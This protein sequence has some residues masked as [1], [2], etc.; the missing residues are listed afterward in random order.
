VEVVVVVDR[1]QQLMTGLAGINLAGDGLPEIVSLAYAGRSAGLG[2]PDPQ[3]R[4]VLVLV[5]SRLLTPLIGR[6]SLV[7]RLDRLVTDVR[8][9]GNDCRLVA[10]QLYQGG[11]QKDGWVLLALRR[12]L[13]Q[14]RDSLGL[15]AVVLVGRFPEAQ[16]LRRF[17]WAPA[18]ERAIS[19]VATAGRRYLA[20]D[21]ELVAASA[22]IVLADLTGRWERLYRPAVTTQAL[23]LLPN[24]ADS[25][26]ADWLRTGREITGNVVQFDPEITTRDVFYLDEA[27]LQQNLIG[28]VARVTIDQ[29]RTDPEIAPANAGSANPIALPEIAV[30]RINAFHVAVRLPADRSLVTGLPGQILDGA[31][32]D[33]Q[34]RPTPFTSTVNYSTEPTADPAVWVIRPDEFAPDPILERRLLAEYLD[35]NHRFR[36]RA[37]PTRPGSVAAVAHP[38]SDGFSAAAAADV[39]ERA[40]P[41]AARTVVQDPT[42]AG[43]ARHWAKPSLLRLLIAHSDARLSEYR[44]TTSTSALDDALGPQ[45]FRWWQTEP[46]PGQSPREFRYLPTTRGL[47]GSVDL[48]VHRTLWQSGKITHVPSILVHNGCGAT[49]PENADTAAYTDPAFGRWQNAES[50]LFY[51]NCLALVGR[52]KVFNDDGHQFVDGLTRPG[53]TLGRGWRNLFAADAR[54]RPEG[55]DIGEQSARCKKSYP[56]NLLGDCTLPLHP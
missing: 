55:S 29:F 6:T 26:T 7:D 2:E 46:V 5:E 12:F 21:P 3:R 35:R 9:E 32:T 34:G 23:Y 39:L 27:R 31:I 45:P 41:G 42:P 22:D 30:S 1:L 20:V 40:L 25:S 15:T 48:R 13:Q 56:W 36:T 33:P 43:Y 53:A 4:L 28:P 49:A 50:I 8:R 52:S 16:I 44:P 19:G 51:T 24:G 18:F 17:P 11:A 47:G 37:W 10:A 54:V 38:A 14:A